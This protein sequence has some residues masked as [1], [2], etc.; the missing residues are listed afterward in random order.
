[1]N[2]GIKVYSKEDVVAFRLTNV[3]WGELSNFHPSFPIWING[4]LFKTSEALYQAMKFPD[5][6]DIQEQIYMA[7]YPRH[8]KEI[9]RVNGYA[10]RS[11]WL[12]VNVDIMRWVLRH[13]LAQNFDGLALVLDKTGDKPIVEHSQYDNFWGAHLRVGLYT[14]RNVLGMLLM[15]LRDH[16]NSANWD[17]LLNVPLLKIENFKLFGRRIRK[18]TQRK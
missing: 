11:D 13:K 8:A 12:E 7:R 5:K 18:N 10:V 9:A 17:Q 4:V 6:P 15:E 2:T 1:M 3:E 16:Y 14:G